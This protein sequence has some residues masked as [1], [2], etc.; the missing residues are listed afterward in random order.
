MKK[1]KRNIG[2]VAFCVFMILG[3]SFVAI[4]QENKYLAFL[5]VAIVVLSIE[6]LLDIKRFYL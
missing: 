6:G 2:W 5:S 1:I 4:M 3:N